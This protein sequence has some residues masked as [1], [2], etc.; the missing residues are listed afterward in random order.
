MYVVLLLLKISFLY[1]FRLLNW[2]FRLFS[3]ASPFSVERY[4]HGSYLRRCVFA[5]AS[6]VAGRA[7]VD[8]A[9]I[10]GRWLVVVVP[11]IARHPSLS[12]KQNREVTEIADG[13]FFVWIYFFASVR[14]R[15]ECL[16]FYKIFFLTGHS[17]GAVS[18]S[19]R[20]VFFCWQLGWWVARQKL[21]GWDSFF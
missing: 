5:L 16:A 20:R 11:P 18:A 19:I 6:S 1:I 3:L 21:I 10:P 12:A 4:L 14:S 8:R 9:T 13:I 2:R 7:N 15:F 17:L